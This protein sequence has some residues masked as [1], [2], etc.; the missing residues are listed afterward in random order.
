MTPSDIP[1]N[2][3]PRPEPWDEDD[4]KIAERP[5]EGEWLGADE[6]ERFG[7]QIR[8]HLERARLASVFVDSPAFMAVT[9]G[10]DHVFVN[11][12]PAYYRLVGRRRLLGKPVR[13]AFPELEG[14][15]YFDLLDRV[16]ETA[17]P[18]TGVERTLPLV[19][20][21][22]H[23]PEPVHVSFV[24]HPLVEDDGSTWG[25]LTH[26]IDLTER[27][28]AHRALERRAR[29][30]AVVAELG[31]EVLGGVSLERL[32]RAVVERAARELS[33][34]LSGMLKP[35]GGG[36]RLVLREGVG[37]DGEGGED[38]EAVGGTV[39]A[40]ADTL[41]G[42]A[43]E[44]REPVSVSGWKDGSA[45]G[46]ADHLA[47]RGIR[48]GLAVAVRSARE[49][50]PHGV[51]AVYGREPR[52]WR[53]EEADFLQSMAHLL[54]AAEAR[55][56]SERFLSTV[57][58]NLPGV[59]Y[60]CR[61]DASWTMQYLSEGCRE[62]TGYPPG[63]LEENREVAYGELIHPEDRERVRAGVEAAV[64]E[65]R[66]FQLIYR[67][68]T[69]G[70]QEKWV[71]EQGRAVDPAAPRGG[72]LEGCLFDVTD[73]KEARDDAERFR[74]LIEATFA[75]L[76][77]AVFVIRTADRT[78]ET[79]NP[80]AERLFGW[81]REELEGS[82]TES[83]HVDR[84]HHVR[85]GRESERALEED[86]VYRGEF[87]MRRKDGSVF[88][89]EHVISYVDGDEEPRRAVSVVRDTTDRKEREEEIRRSRDLL[90]AVVEGTSDAIFVK[91]RSGE[92]VFANS[93]ASRLLAG[94]DDEE[95]VGH[96]DELLLDD[97]TLGMIRKVDE[98]VLASG[99]IRR[100]EQMMPIGTEGDP[101]TF[102]TI[103]AP[104]RRSDGETA[105]I[106]GFARDITEKKET[107]ER[108]RKAENKYRSVFHVTPTTL[109]IATLEEGRLLEIND[110]F[111]ELYGWTRE[112]A[113]G[114]TARELNLWPRWQKR[115]RLVQKL[116]RDERVQNVELQM[117]RRDGE[118]VDVLFSA[119][120]LE[121][122]DE[123][124]LLAATQDISDRKEAEQELQ[125]M[126]L[127]D[128]LTGLPNRNL[129]RDR[130]EHAL[131]RARRMGTSIAVLFLDLDRFKVVNDTLGHP[132][133]D[134]LL[135]EVARRI[136]SCFRE[137]DTVARLGGDEF[138]GLVE[139]LHSEDQVRVVADRLVEVFDP[140]FEVAGT[141]VHTQASIGIATSEGGTERP[142]D[143]LRFSDVAM[144]RVKN[145]KGTRY[146]VFDPE[147]DRPETVRLH[148]ENDLR[149]AVAEG[150]FFLEFQPTVRLSDR[151]ILG[152][153][154]LVRWDHPERGRV[155]PDE[156]IPLAE[157]TGLIVPLG[158]WVLEEACRVVETW[159]RD[160]IP[161]D[162]PF[163]LSVN[164]SGRQ[165]HEPDLVERV[166]AIA[167]STGLP[168]ERLQLE[169]TESVL[170]TG[171]GRLQEL[172]DRG[173]QIAIDDFGTGYSSLQ[174]L[175]RLQADV[176][177]VDRTF[178]ADLETDP[179]DSVVVEAIMMV[180]GQFG[181]DVVAEGIETE[182]Q[183]GHLADLGCA[184]GQG[185]LFARPMSPDTFTDLLRRGSPGG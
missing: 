137:E 43:L 42:R 176:L 97:E 7:D 26:G 111:K 163:T 85:F 73:W 134:M 4:R 109:S 130:L 159:L 146:H 61:N 122:D 76:E 87:R 126:A 125:R 132:A 168:P 54:G 40:G 115:E 32:H 48:C 36:E 147:Q 86:G 5:A 3:P 106:I 56:E 65:G 57:A 145:Q 22:D 70:G 47:T 184:V 173:V 46:E 84:E 77:D 129:F 149:A 98:E 102:D 123:P 45:V 80:A 2:R 88:Y 116:K 155:P 139:D 181:I 27:W 1:S 89:T 30:Q 37:W 143:L 170:M 55:E 177:K 138:A 160:V 167:E 180:A 24:Y 101:R 28:R 12:N 179:R 52:L 81:D 151:V 83:L 78:I 63:A 17:E 157:E 118:V 49:E 135:Q 114:R 144:Y 69:R 44:A 31:R 127:R 150:Q 38:G 13:E 58:A 14:G 108:L 18:V 162:D 171:R 21:P 11:T 174:Y 131:E 103:V 33:V 172:R 79:C 53:P 82:G 148:R 104:Y 15:E 183:L 100:F 9:R 133:G 121:L 124:C 39:P 90:E 92:I 72:T 136:R 66:P 23:P 182:A 35:D 59:L 6:P 141:E 99:E 51:L 154:A 68:R 10:P 62:L 166:L 16:Y 94:P 142:D 120:L 178:V 140:P 107:E 8:E 50:E 74:R 95:I 20:S 158:E 105:G 25:I 185:F 161:A 75:S 164:L 41:E 152:A 113:V 153:E 119:E 93:A 71:W 19:R 128:G 34:P 67:I 29:Q 156:F 64:R 165:C 175:R 112:E 169:I 117:Q 96:R 110:G 60:R 91:D